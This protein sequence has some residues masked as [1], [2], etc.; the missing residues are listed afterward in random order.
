V[1]VTLTHPITGFTGVITVLE[2]VVLSFTSG[3]A[4]EDVP[5]SA[6]GVIR[7]LGILINATTGSNPPYDANLDAVV[8]PIVTSTNSATRT[9]LGAALVTRAEGR[10]TNARVAHLEEPLILGFQ[11]PDDAITG[12][13]HKPLNDL[14]VLAATGATSAR[15]DMYWQ[16]AEPTTKGA[17]AWDKYDRIF[18][19]A[20]AAGVRVLWNI[21]RV[22]DWARTGADRYS[23]P[24]NPQDYGDF[25]AAAAARYD[26]R[27]PIQPAWELWNEPNLDSYVDDVN[28]IAGFQA[29]V[30]AG[31]AGI[32]QSAPTST[33]VLAGLLRGGIEYAAEAAVVKSD[34][35][36][37]E[38]FY[39]AGGGPGVTHDAVGF[40]A[41]CYPMDPA[42]T[43]PTGIDTGPN[44]ARNP[45]A[46]FNVGQWTATRGT[47]TRDTTV[48][49]SGAASFKLAADGS[50]T[51]GAVCAVTPAAP[52]DYFHDV[53]W[54]YSP[55][56]AETFDF[57]VDF[58]DGTFASLGSSMGDT[59][60]TKVGEWIKVGARSSTV[61]APAGTVYAVIGFTSHDTPPAGTVVNFD[62]M[63]LHRSSDERHGWNRVAPVHEMM[64]AHGDTSPMWITEYGQH[65]GTDADAVDEATQATYLVNAITRAKT[66]PYVDAL[67]LFNLRNNGTDGARENNFGIVRND[68][69]TKPAFQPVVDALGG[70]GMAL[71]P[72]LLFAD[73]FD[74]NTAGQNWPSLVGTGLSLSTAA[75]LEGSQS[76]RYTHTDGN[77]SGYV[78][79]NAPAAGLSEL[80]V[81]FLFRPTTLVASDLSSLHTLFQLLAPFVSLQFGHQTSTSSYDWYFS[82]NGIVT[83]LPLVQGQEVTVTVHHKVSSG[84]TD[85]IT[86]VWINGTLL[87][88]VTHNTTTAITGF[89]FGNA[90]ANKGGLGTGTVFD[91]DDVRVGSTLDAIS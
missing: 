61:V 87:A 8:A 23:F 89:R 83:E 54:F 37:L 3:T 13:W 60:T 59:F 34:V 79:W 19:A 20:S 6:F 30:A 68:W 45:D 84:A 5:P 90:Q 14:A 9:A 16:D 71:P 51:Y 67:F 53:G 22:P 17:Y 55:T 77:T 24:D 43:T 80:W 65:A 73:R 33:V 48:H 66:F 82:S 21:S 29:L 36:W 58:L 88:T 91:F 64:L 27:G 31:Y 72:E 1:E 40:H 74:G 69:T 44:L 49:H 42:D 28:D 85:G 86:E 15:L 63:A 41:Y 46:E 76:L 35:R 12:G 47:I 81:S 62:D 25:C 11:V 7:D 2:T 70:V 38:E 26:A 56:T 4:N 10:A 50:G 39:A 18:D 57:R 75:P 78:Q 32:K 52:G